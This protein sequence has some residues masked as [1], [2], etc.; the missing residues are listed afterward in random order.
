MLFPKPPAQL[1]PDDPGPTIG[2]EFIG[3]TNAQ[4]Q[5]RLNS[6][7]GGA[8]VPKD[9]QEFDRILGLVGSPATDRPVLD[10]NPLPM[11][12]EDDGFDLDLDANNDHA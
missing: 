9:A 11:D 10:P 4:I 7:F 3:V 6:S 8:I 1:T 5:A 2:R 12:D